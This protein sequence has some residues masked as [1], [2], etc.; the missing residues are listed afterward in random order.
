MREKYKEGEHVTVFNLG[1]S[2]P[3][4]IFRAVVRGIS[5][6]GVARIYIVEMIDKIE[7]LNYV[8]THC[9]MPEACLKPGWE[10]A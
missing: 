8:Y 2:Y 6:D 4:R 1:P 5:V 9:T 7:P 10:E 3:N